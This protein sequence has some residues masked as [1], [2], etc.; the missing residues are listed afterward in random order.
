MF[1]WITELMIAPVLSSY[2]CIN[3]QNNVLYGQLHVITFLTSELLGSVVQVMMR[4][5]ASLVSLEFTK[6]GASIC[7]VSVSMYFRMATFTWDTGNKE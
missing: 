4:D 7:N 3:C 5:T 6:S 2:L 1:L